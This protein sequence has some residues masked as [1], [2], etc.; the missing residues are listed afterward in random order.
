MKEGDKFDLES[1][2][3]LKPGRWLKHGHLCGELRTLTIKAAYG[4]CFGQDKKTG[5]DIIRG[6]LEFEETDLHY[7]TPKTVDKCLSAMFGPK[8]SDLIGKRVTFYTDKD[9]FA[10]DMVDCIRVAGSPDLPE[11]IECLVKYAQR[12]GR[13]DKRFV[14]KV[15]DAPM[16]RD[17]ETIS[18]ANRSLSV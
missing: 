7:S 13:P 18:R 2:E 12:T 8:P 15:T 4:E 16:D 5:R 6:V 11:Q 10:R 14:L 9:R 1:Y 3:D 17:W